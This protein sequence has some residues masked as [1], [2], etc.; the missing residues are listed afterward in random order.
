MAVVYNAYTLIDVLICFFLF[1]RNI[2]KRNIRIIQIVLI[3][4]FLFTA[5]ALYRKSGFN[6]FHNELVC[7]DSIIQMVWV[8]FFFYERYKDEKILRLQEQFIFWFCLGLLFYSPCT[9]F[10]FAFRKI[11][12]DELA[13]LWGMHSVL[14][15]L[16][17]VLITIGFFANYLKSK[18]IFHAQ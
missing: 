3:C 6:T 12:N 11:V 4:V 1:Y 8:L 15:I 9:Y 16:M 5:I 13:Y 2:Q 14:N 7:F 18:R 10:L 17:Y